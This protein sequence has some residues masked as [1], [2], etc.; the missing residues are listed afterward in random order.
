MSETSDD[1]ADK[2]LIYACSGCSSAAQLANH[3]A[4]RMDRGRRAEMSCVVGLGGDV[5]PLVRTAKSGRPIV[6]LDGCPLRCGQNTLARHG[7]SPALHWDL[8][9]LGVAKEKHVD[10]RAEDAT[11]LEP[12]LSEALAALEKKNA[13]SPDEDAA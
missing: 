10:F 11:R 13:V 7:L 3:L 8:S 5:K 9:R 4:L 12:L 1:Y 6:M 2:P